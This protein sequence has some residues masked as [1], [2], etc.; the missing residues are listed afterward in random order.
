MCHRPFFTL[1]VAA[2]LVGHVL[3]AEEL[4]P[5]EATEYWSPEPPVVATSPD[6]PPSDAII[7]FD[8]RTF[9]SFETVDPHSPGWKLADGAMEIVPK[10]GGL[11]TKA[12][13]GDVQL[14]IEFRTP[15]EIKGTSQARGNSGVFFMGLYELQVLDSYQ[16]KTYVNGQAGSIYKQ[17]PPLV[18]ASRPPGEWQTYDAIFIAPRFS[19]DG[20]LVS[21]ARV[22][23]FH[24]GVLVQ[25]DVALRGG[26]VYR[27]SPTY[28]AHPDKLPLQLQNH[29]NP[30]AYR[31]IWV[32][33]L[34]L[35]DPAAPMR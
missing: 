9:D 27:G 10:T 2:L 13:F 14:H 12:S 30:V 20:K 29:G 17:Y 31:N 19:A 35:P 4:P 11:R 16:N 28:T 26:T 7:L 6:R 21:P 5:P 18:N 23:V 8:G 22:T 15:R 1:V 25:H 32:R 33:E 24:N 3:A 34:T